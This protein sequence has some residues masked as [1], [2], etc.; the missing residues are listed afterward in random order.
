MVF[1]GYD[2]RYILKENYDGDFLDR[3]FDGDADGS[4]YR[5]RSP[6]GVGGPSGD[7]SVLSEDVDDFRLAYEKRNDR[8]IDDLEAVVELTR[9]L[10]QRGMVDEEVFADQMEEV[11]DA[12]QWARFFAVMAT[13]TNR[14]GGIWNDSGEDYFLYRLPDDSGRASAGKWWLMA[15]DVEETFANSEERLFRP[16]LTATR[17]F[18]THPRF[19][20]MYYEELDWIRRDVFARREMLRRFGIA[21]ALHEPSDV[22]EIVDE[23]DAFVSRRLGYFDENVSSQLSGGAVSGAGGGELTIAG[24]A[25]WRF[26]RGL[27]APS[28]GIRDWATLEYDDADWETGPS[29]FGYGDDDDATVLD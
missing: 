10:A 18:L 2:S 22:F 11:I 26:F 6:L 27:R 15:W 25:E 4:L 23:V 1:R 16:E 5:A 8:E 13:M 24:G 3:Y 29:G 9:L 19:A 7:L 12:R 28:G 14:D 17:A 20:A 21:Y